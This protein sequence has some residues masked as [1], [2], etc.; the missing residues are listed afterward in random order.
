M[1]DAKN[2]I[3]SSAMRMVHWALAAAIAF[4]MMPFM[5]GHLGTRWYGIWVLIAGLF[6]S[7]YLLDFGL[8][9]AVTRF[10]STHLA[11]G[12]DE[13]ANRV[14][15]SSLAIYTV[16]AGVIVLLTVLTAV[17]IERIPAL[18]NDLGVVRWVVILVGLQFAAE[19]P[20]KA[21]AGIPPSFVRYDILTYP[22]LFNLVLSTVLTVYVLERGLGI[23]ALALVGFLCAQLGNVSY[24]FV[25]RHLFPNLR[26]SRQ[27][28]S[29]AMVARLFTFGGWA[30]VVQVANQL[31]F[32]VDSLVIASMLSA[33][34]V[35]YYAVGLGLV[36]YFVDLVMRAT[37]LML[38]VFTRYWVQDMR[39]E[40]RTKF[41]LLSRINA[42]LGV[43]GGGLIVIVGR[44]FIL[45]WM[46]S[47]F[48]AS[49]PVLVVLMAG[50][51]TE[52]V[53]CYADNVFYAMSKH[54]YL[55]IAN[56]LE[57][58]V[59]LGLSIALARPLGL[60]GVALGTTVPLIFFRLVVIPRWVAKSLAFPVARY[61][62]NLAPTVAFTL[63]Y[64]FCC[65]WLAGGFLSM[66]SYGVVVA[67]GAACTPVYALTIPFVAFTKKERRDLL[68]TVRGR[69][70]ADVSRTRP[71]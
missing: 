63:G 24:V 14:V 39:Q 25:A 40:L 29:R 4:F 21:F 41:L 22:R 13:A 7:Y 61:Y 66:P 49:Y 53:G 69:R 44:P 27:L 1:S 35:T 51:A 3:R 50:M 47:D 45:R 43:F 30:F 62:A 5:V 6:S 59:N 11:T 23:A 18:K 31:R 60:V 2:L 19:F 54:K 37:N 9:A 32:K 48:E 46:G 71:D 65:H 8:A 58:L 55:A 16:L 33:S 70:S 10:F 67:V 34:A 64:L 52:I 38:P 28:V 17:F 26:L 15:N 68:N 36:E 20:V 12:D 56:I 57:G 42:I